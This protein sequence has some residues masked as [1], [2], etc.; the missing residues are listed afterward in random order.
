MAYDGYFYKDALNTTRQIV[1]YSTPDFLFVDSEAFT[2]WSSW[3][4]DVGLSANANARRQTAE[5]DAALAYR[6]VKEF[7]GQYNTIVD[8]ASDGATTV[9]F[10]GASA[11]Q[12]AGVGSFPWKILGDLSQAAQPQ[13]YGAWDTRNL[14]D[15]VTLIRAQ[16]RALEHEA[17]A[18]RLLPW[19]TVDTYG[20]T[21]PTSCFDQL[22]H[23]FLNGASGVS[24]FSCEAT[25]PILARRS[26][27]IV[28]V[29][30]R[31]SL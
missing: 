16:K 27:T 2:P 15:F 23:T 29:V 19:L 9:G 6:M 25:Q 20:H 18:N 1:Q 30:L 7:M 22:I 26:L 14:P 21:T 10:F 31:H 17:L 13:Y 4:L 24:Y 5:T 3:L 28:R 8:Q 12:N 11:A